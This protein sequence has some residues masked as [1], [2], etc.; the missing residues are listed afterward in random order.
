MAALHSATVREMKA[1]NYC[2]D[3]PDDSEKTVRKKN[4]LRKAPPL[5]RRKKKNNGHR[6]TMPAEHTV[7]PESEKITEEKTI[8]GGRSNAAMSRKTKRCGKRNTEKEGAVEK[9][10]VET[11]TNR[12]EPQPKTARFA[13]DRKTCR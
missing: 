5:C 4:N 8:T 7:S 12:R 11:K 2:K 1:F 6:K 3:K 9:G 10:K 13:T